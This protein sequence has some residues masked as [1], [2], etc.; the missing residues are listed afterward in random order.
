MI[1]FLSNFFNH[2]QS[3]LAD[4]LYRLTGGE[5]RFIEMK[6]MPESFLANGY[7]DLSSRPYLVKAWKDKKSKQAARNLFVEAEK[8]IYGG[9]Y[10][11]KWIDERLDANRLTFEYGERWLK[12]GWF[13]LLSPNLLKY[14]WNHYRKY[15]NKPLYRLN[16]GAYAA[17]D[18]RRLGIF[19]NKCF[20]W[21]YFVD[22]PTVLYS[23]RS[24]V[25]S[26]PM[27]L[28]WVARFIP[29]KRWEMP[30]RMMA[31]LKG[32][33]LFCRLKMIGTGSKLGDARKLACKYGVEG[34]IEFA[35]NIPNE[36]VIAEMRK[37]DICIFTSNRREGWGAVISESL[38][39]GCP[40]V[41]SV[42]AGAAPWQIVEGENGY[43]FRNGDVDELTEKVATMIRNP[44]KTREMGE[45]AYRKMAAEWTPRIAAERWLKLPEDKNGYISRGLYSDGVCSRE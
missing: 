3:A 4:E 41:S 19:K 16:N 38:A 23:H 36:A 12:R 39:N 2:H 45:R 5:F 6:Q 15:R 28:I 26:E 34:M 31:K 33:G 18:M 37:S 7:P 30:I 25:S 32:M 42:E 9:F 17:P 14:L 10:P 43:I 8:A 24:A 35:G 40:V 1:V 29:L 44:E 11:Y 13:N 20:R 22:V 21:G 27:K